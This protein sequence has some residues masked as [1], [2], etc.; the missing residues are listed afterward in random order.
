[1]GRAEAGKPS[2][3]PIFR[4][5]ERPE[6]AAKRS[7]LLFQFFLFP[8]LIVIA[9]VA[10]FLLFGLIGGS[11]KSPTEL[12]QDVTSGGENVQKQSAQQIAA[13]LQDE[14]ARVEKKEIPLEKAFY[15]EPGFRKGLLA[16]FTQSFPDRSLERK[17]LLA[18]SLGFVGDPAYLEALTQHLSAGEPETLRAAVTKA[19]AALDTEDVVPVLAPLVEDAYEPVRNFAVFGLAR[20]DLPASRTAVR[21]ALSDPSDFVKVNAAAALAHWKEDPGLDLLGKLLDPEWVTRAVHT[22]APRDAGDTGKDRPDMG[23]Q[24][25]REALKNGIRGAHALRAASLRARV[26]ALQD[27]PDPDVRKVARQAIDGW[28][29]PK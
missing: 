5:E 14:R 3:D 6:P 26:A 10:V 13:R 20:H 1:V 18:H 29:A 12:L 16:A 24:M 9:S 21:K 17:V 4:A 23:T 25:R 19:I 22:E 11:E 27:D 8:L 2:D 28:P 7:T 15:V